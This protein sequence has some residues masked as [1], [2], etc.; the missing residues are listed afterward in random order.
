MNV[1]KLLKSLGYP[2]IIFVACCLILIMVRRGY[3]EVKSYEM[4]YPPLVKAATDGDLTL[5]RHLLNKGADPNI[6]SFD[7]TTALHFVCRNGDDTRIEDIL[8]LL[9]DVGSRPALADQ[10]GYVPLFYVPT[11]AD[12]DKRNRFY[13]ELVMSGADINESSKLL[14]DGVNGALKNGD[15]RRKFTMLDITVNNF[16]RSG[17]RSALETWGAFLS[18]ETIDRAEAYAY[19]LGFGYIGRDI[20]DFKKRKR[21]VSPSQITPL[22]L[23]IV[24]RD[25]KQVPLLARDKSNINKIS[26][27]RFEQTA[28]HLALKCDQY[29]SAVEIVKNGGRVDIGDYLGNRP[30]HIVA[31]SG[32]IELQK[33]SVPLLVKAGARLDAKNKYGDTPLMWAI[34]FRD[35]PFIKYLLA[36]Y[37][38][39]IRLG[40]IN[41]DNMSASDL[42]RLYDMKELAPKLR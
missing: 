14:I 35:V 26:N 33:K 11:I 42:A 23:A 25:E 31:G 16:D 10:K 41:R 15:E 36:T 29:E 38:K 1:Y 27:D 8:R 21:L 19:D 18:P 24:R 22:M 6:R 34:R 39:E 5:V 28:L 37:P 40:A 13:Y 12:L 17:V 9:I 3:G 20:T 32:D 2:P 4:V 7:G 30:L